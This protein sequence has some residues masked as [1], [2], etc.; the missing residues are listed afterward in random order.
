MSTGSDK[1]IT[2]MDNHTTHDLESTLTEQCGRPVRVAGCANTSLRIVFDPIDDR[3]RVDLLATGCGLRWTLTDRGA[4]GALYDL[5]LDFVTEKL[6]EF[7]TALTRCGE[8]LVADTEDRSL[9]EAVV[10]F[11]DSLE[12]VPVLAGLFANERTA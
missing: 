6:A 12:F 2:P 7:D 5:D 9:V 11:V 1:G 3:G 10:A 4:V 8:E